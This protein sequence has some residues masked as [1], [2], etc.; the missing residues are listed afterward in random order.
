MGIVI[1]RQMA[2]PAEIGEPLMKLV[3]RCIDAVDQGVVHLG[4]HRDPVP[5]LAFGRGVN[6]IEGPTAQRVTSR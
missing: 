5:G 3:R 1:G 2:F 4:D 6:V